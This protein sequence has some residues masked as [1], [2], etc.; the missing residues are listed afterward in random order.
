[1]KTSKSLILFFLFAIGNNTSSI[2]AQNPLV[3]DVGMADPHIHIFNNKAYLYATKDKDSLSTSRTW[4]NPYWHIWSSSDLT[5]W[6][7][8]IPL[9]LKK[10]I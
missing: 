5:N 6:S 2:I 7:L 8:E 4:N 9:N 3:P 1:M 10:L